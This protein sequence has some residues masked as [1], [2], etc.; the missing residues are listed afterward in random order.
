MDFIKEAYRILKPGGRLA[1]MEAFRL[2]ENL[3]KE[4]ERL[5]RKLCNC[6]HTDF[7][8]KDNFKSN[9]LKVGFK[10]IKFHDKSN[11]VQK[12]AS[13][14]YWLTMPFF[15][16]V[17]IFRKLRIVSETFYN[18]IDGLREQKNIFDSNFLT[19]GVFVAEKDR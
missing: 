14:N 13:I 18:L 1:V 19:Y 2:K 17:W 12:T 8:H 15:P 7:A 11:N 9:L 6:F 10:N 16:V 5:Y 3:N 4:E